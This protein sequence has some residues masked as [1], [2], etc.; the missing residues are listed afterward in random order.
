MS[1]AGLKMNIVDIVDFND[2]Y[3][4]MRSKW[5]TV[6]TTSAARSMG[7]CDHLRALESHTPQ[8]LT[9]LLDSGWH[10]LRD[11]VK[12]ILQQIDAYSSRRIQCGDSLNRTLPPGFLRSN[13]NDSALEDDAQDRG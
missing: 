4:G 6:Y 12:L 9:A 5:Y 8:N 11:R 13:L 7:H 3:V 10:S 1:V 2:S